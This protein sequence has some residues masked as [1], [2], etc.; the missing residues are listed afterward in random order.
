MFKTGLVSSTNYLINYI[1]ILVEFGAPLIKKLPTYKLC[2]LD[3]SNSVSHWIQ[4]DLG[5]VRQVSGIRSRG[6]DTPPFAYVKFFEVQYWHN[7]TWVHVTENDHPKVLYKQHTSLL[8][9]RHRHTVYSVLF[10]LILQKFVGNV[11]YTTIVYNK[12]PSIV[13]TS[14]IR[15]IPIAWMV[16]ACC[17]LDI[18]GCATR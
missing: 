16:R 6:R 14:K 17:Q 3:S 4:F 11:D 1:N 18:M 10:F 12:L 15:F 9:T 13:S 5:V 2:F 7:S 8:A